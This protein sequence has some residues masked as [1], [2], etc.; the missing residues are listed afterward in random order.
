MYRIHAAGCQ[1]HR[2]RCCNLMCCHS[3]WHHQTRSPP[4]HPLSRHSFLL[5]PPHLHGR[6]TAH[7]GRSC[8]VFVYLWLLRWGAGLADQSE[9]M[10]RELGSDGTL[11]QGCTGCLWGSRERWRQEPV[12]CRGPPEDSHFWGPVCMRRKRVLNY[13]HQRRYS[14]G[15]VAKSTWE[16]IQQQKDVT[17][18]N[19]YCS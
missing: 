12:A 7:G 5:L 8:D 19:S 3:K 14:F 18:I 11:V 6:A 10:G 4:R 16:E 2:T 9:V 13:D 15:S 1:S 17:D